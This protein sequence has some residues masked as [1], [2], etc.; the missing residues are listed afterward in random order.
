MKTAVTLTGP[1]VPRVRKAGRAGVRAPRW[2]R[3][4]ELDVDWTGTALGPPNEFAP[5]RG[6]ERQTEKPVPDLAG[7]GEA[8]LEESGNEPF[9]P[10]R[11]ITGAQPMKKLDDTLKVPRIDRHRVDVAAVTVAHIALQPD[12][13]AS[14]R[15]ARAFVVHKGCHF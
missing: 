8:D 3:R 1:A 15:V 12:C 9:G 7:P 5:H 13:Q 6:G 14:H 2:R 10:A 4:E 11:D